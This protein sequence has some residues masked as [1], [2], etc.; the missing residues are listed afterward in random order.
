MS[1]SK[2]KRIK[3]LKMNARQLGFSLVAADIN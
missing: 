2:E 1:K 3:R